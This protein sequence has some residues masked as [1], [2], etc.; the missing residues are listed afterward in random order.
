[1]HPAISPRGSC[2]R[3]NFAVL[4]GQNVQQSIVHFHMF[5]DRVAPLARKQMHTHGER[6]LDDAVSI[7][8]FPADGRAAALMSGLRL[9]RV[10]RPKYVDAD[11]LSRRENH[12]ERIDSNTSSSITTM[13]TLETLFIDPVA[14]L[15][16]AP[17]PR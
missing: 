1:M 5:G 12:A 17:P 6:S 10:V 8:I 14:F 9:V 3:L 13:L 16:C 11:A 15:T 4:G 2:L 7:S